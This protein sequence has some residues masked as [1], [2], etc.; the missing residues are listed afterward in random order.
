MSETTAP[1]KGQS[2][3]MRL[4]LILSV[5]LNLAIAGLVIGASLKFRAEPPPPI[6]DLN[7]GDFSAAMTPG[8]RA[9]LRRHFVDQ[10]PDLGQLRGQMR[11]E[12]EALLVILRA[13]PFDATGFGNALAETRKRHTER[14]SQAEAALREV[15]A[16]MSSAERRDLA[17]RVEAE[18]RRPPRKGPPNGPHKGARGEMRTDAAPPPPVEE[19]AVGLGADGGSADRGGRADAAVNP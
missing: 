18:M 1:A 14:S 7:F 8:Q 15:I 17:A 13:E 11:R 12:R 4:A 16:Q 10:A 3:F 2:R 5:A 19:T 9:D 6:R